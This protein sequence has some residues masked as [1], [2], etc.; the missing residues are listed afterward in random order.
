MRVRA[1]RLALAVRAK[2]RLEPRASRSRRIAAST[3]PGKRCAGWTASGKCFEILEVPIEFPSHA[4]PFMRHAS[5]TQMDR[6]IMPA[7]SARTSAAARYLLLARAVQCET[8]GAPAHR[9]R[10]EAIDETLDSSQPRWSNP[11][12]AKDAR[13]TTAHCRITA[14]PGRGKPVIKLWNESRTNRA[15]IADSVA[16][17]IRSRRHLVVASVLTT[18]SG[19]HRQSGTACPWGHRLTGG[20]T[21]TSDL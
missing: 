8:Q 10:R 19:K 1:A 4:T 14:L 12:R 16:V 21:G 7:R 15:R 17:G 18:K 9:N 13:S 5:G 2:Q 3:M 6:E 11:D 20:A